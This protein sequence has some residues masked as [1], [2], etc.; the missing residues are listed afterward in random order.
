MNIRPSPRMMY[1][2]DRRLA[3]GQLSAGQTATCTVVRYNE[4]NVPLTALLV[5]PRPTGLTFNTDG[6]F[7]YT[8]PANAGVSHVYVPGVDD[9]GAIGPATVTISVN[10]V[11][12]P[13]VVTV[14]GGGRPRRMRTRSSPDRRQRSRR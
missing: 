5:A 1:N 4:N 7:V 13:P 14:P 12:D 3:D 11:N 2:V 10:A 9:L 8:P 6:T